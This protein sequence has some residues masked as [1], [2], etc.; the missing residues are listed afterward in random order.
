MNNK[1]LVFSFVML[2]LGTFFAFS[3]VSLVFAAPYNSAYSSGGG[4]GFGGMDIR[5][6]SEMLIGFFVDWSEPFL[7]AFLGG[8][9]YTGYLLFEKFLLFI[10][11]MSLVYVSVKNIPVFKDQKWVIWTISIIVPIIGVRF[12]DFE[13]LNTVFMQYQ[14]LAVALSGILPF[15]IYLF[16]LHNAFQGPGY[17]ATRK[18]GWV[19][20]IVVYY[21]LW[22]TSRENNYGEVYFWTMLISVLFLFLDGT[23]QR[24]LMKQK[25]AESFNEELGKAV[26]SLEANRRQIQNSSMPDATKKGLLNKLDRDISNLVKKMS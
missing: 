17:S 25:W 9:D 8:Y 19:F 15:I 23:I 4:S 10:L 1:K 22:S 26:A 20:F 2:L 11:L 12:L 5:Q 18:I 16:F 24:A 13:W 3:L 14:V 21:G 6:G 7:Q